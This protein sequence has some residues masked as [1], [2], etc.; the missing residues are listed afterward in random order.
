[1][2]SFRYC[3]YVH[4]HTGSDGVLWISPKYWGPQTLGMMLLHNLQV[5]RR[6]LSKRRLLASFTG[7]NI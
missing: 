1:M 7:G 5:V 4:G 2:P 6:M 3:K